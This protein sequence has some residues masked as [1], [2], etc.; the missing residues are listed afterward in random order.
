MKLKFLLSIL[1]C[2]CMLCGMALPAAAAVLPPQMLEE[3]AK[4]KARF[5]AM[6]KEKQAA[7]EEE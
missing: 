7:A 6:A 4:E 3:M 5:D 1:L 2:L